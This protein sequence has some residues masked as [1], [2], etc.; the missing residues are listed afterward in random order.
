M[1]LRERK[2]AK[3]K[4]EILRSALSLISEKG[5]Y[6]TTMEDIAANLLMTKGSVYYY[7]KDKQ[8]LVFQSYLMLL[9]ESS[10]R[11]EVIQQ[12]N[13]PII[14]KL[15]ETMNSH[16]SCLL[17]ERSGFELGLKPEQ[18]FT[19]EQLKVVAEKREEYAGYFE[20]LIIEGKEAK[21]FQDVDVKIVRNIILGAMNWL[22]Q[23][24][25]PNGKL[26]SD[27]MADVVSNYLL[28]ML[29]ESDDI[30]TK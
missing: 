18:F 23:W 11:F 14:D 4:E 28:R 19:D 13:L 7:F 30:V 22:L 17:S 25:S 15:R 27:E 12:K 3:K 16:I 20:K 10:E 26:N 8:D 5:Y 6:A 9:E 29:L 1:S 24:Y 2:A 21:I